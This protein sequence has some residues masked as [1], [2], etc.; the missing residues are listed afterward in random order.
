MSGI[1][2]ISPDM[3]SGVVGKYPVGNVVQVSGGQASAGSGTQTASWQVNA[4]AFTLRSSSN[5]VM[6]SIST[7]ACSRS[8]ATAGV[9]YL[10]GGGFGATT[11]GRQVADSLLQGMVSG[12]REQQNFQAED[13][14][15]GTSATYGMYFNNTS[16]NAFQ[17]YFVNY[18]IIEIQT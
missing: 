6:F 7:T 10:T 16:G 5:N 3:R 14:N 13:T 1:I 11:S 18:L 15:P 2:S 12:E 4:P 8:S 9:M 17:F